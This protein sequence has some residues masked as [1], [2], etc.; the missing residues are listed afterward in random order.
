MRSPLRLTS[1]AVALF[2]L[3]ATSSAE[4]LDVPQQHFKV[5]FPCQSQSDVKTTDKGKGT[6]VFTYYSCPV[7][8][9]W[10]RVWVTRYPAAFDPAH[11]EG[12]LV[13]A[14][15]STEKALHGSLEYKSPHFSGLINGYYFRMYTLPDKKEETIGYVFISGDVLYDVLC[16]G[17]EGQALV[18]GWNKFSGGF[19]VYG[20][21]GQAEIKAPEPDRTYDDDNDYGC[22]YDEDCSDDD[23]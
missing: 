10:Y 12:Y 6:V 14:V 18:D 21:P 5:T 1:V 11:L 2:A 22:D 7:G 16:T 9:V 20:V 19:Q 17:P 3:G 4:F 8:D 23:Y 13:G 15:S